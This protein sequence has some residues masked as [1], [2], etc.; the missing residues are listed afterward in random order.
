MGFELTPFQ[1]IVQHLT[2][3]DTTLYTCNLY[4]GDWRHCRVVYC[5]LILLYLCISI[6]TYVYISY[7]FILIYPFF[8]NIA[9]LFSLY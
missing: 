7:I 6:F 8:F 3:G 4:F 9:L 2:H 1:S 5:I